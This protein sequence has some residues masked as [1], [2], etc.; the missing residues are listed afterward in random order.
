M[1]QFSMQRRQLRMYEEVRAYESEK[2]KKK[3]KKKTPI[4]IPSH[5]KPRTNAL[6]SISFHET[7][8]HVLLTEPNRNRRITGRGIPGPPILPR[9]RRVHFFALRDFPSYRE[10]AFPFCRLGPILECPWRYGPLSVRQAEIRELSRP[11][12]L[13]VTAGSCT[14]ILLHSRLVPD[15]VEVRVRHGLLG[16]KPFLRD[17]VSISF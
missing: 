6:H 5:R 15:R 13:R 14:K 9:R 11:L 2:T 17:Y 8:S 16:G 7:P 3:K 4:C 10:A 1:V 12:L